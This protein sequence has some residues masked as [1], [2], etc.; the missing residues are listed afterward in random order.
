MKKINEK[1]KKMSAETSLA[2]DMP[3]G[4]GSKATP[5]NKSLD[6]ENFL[7]D[8][9]A[10]NKTV[11]KATIKTPSNKNLDAEDYLADGPK[12]KKSVKKG[13]KKL[14]AENDLSKMPK[15][16][17]GSTN[18]SSKMDAEEYLSDAK[19]M[20]SFSKFTNENYINELYLRG[21]EYA[22]GTP[23]GNTDIDSDGNVTTTPVVD[24]RGGLDN[25][26]YLE[27]SNNTLKLT[28]NKENA[29]C[30]L[31]D[32]EAEEYANHHMLTNYQLETDNSGENFTII[33]LNSLEGADIHDEETNEEPNFNFNDNEFDN[34]ESKP[35]NYIKRPYD[36]Q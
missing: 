30:F 15:Y 29:H 26:M 34:E 14:K 25:K 8:M 28:D 19:H 3:K 35:L 23:H 13:N 9:P 27:I 16:G 17:K 22:D 12:F 6:A 7:A 18:S 21:G 36:L 24:D 2:N 10:G 20:K 4:K 31:D 1:E 11:K 33:A 32:E 5:S